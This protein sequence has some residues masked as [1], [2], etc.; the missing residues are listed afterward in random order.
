MLPWSL[1][2]MRGG[3]PPFSNSVVWILVVI[4]DDKRTARA[5][6]LCKRGVEFGHGWLLA[7]IRQV[8]DLVSGKQSRRSCALDLHWLYRNAA[9]DKRQCE[10][11]ERSKLCVGR[12]R[13]GALKH[14]GVRN[15]NADAF[16]PRALPSHV[17]LLH[18]SQGADD[19]LQFRLIGP[20]DLDLGCLAIYRSVFCR[21]MLAVENRSEER[22]VGKECRSRWSPYH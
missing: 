11:I 6:P 19:A 5:H 1:V 2:C 18:I 15:E 10:P 17:R 4:D 14:H 7:L 8:Q 20:G 22:R 9:L 16:R 21:E 12:H 13:I 3:V